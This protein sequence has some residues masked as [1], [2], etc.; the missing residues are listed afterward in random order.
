M[1]GNL[2]QRAKALVLCMMENEDTIR[3]AGRLGISKST[4]YTN[5]I[6]GLFG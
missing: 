3:A 1:E 2:E 5:V 4:V 6:N